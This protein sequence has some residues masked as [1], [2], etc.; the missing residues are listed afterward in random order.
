[1]LRY[2]L[3][4]YQ[5]YLMV[6]LYV[7]IGVYG[8]PAL[9]IFLPLSVFFMKS[10]EL[11]GDMLFGL[12]IVL[13][14]S[15][16]TPWFFSMQIFKGAKNT[17]ISA[18]ALIFFLERYRFVPF[19]K[20]FNV[21]FPFFVYSFFPLI[22]SGTIIVSVQKTISYALL[23]LIIP[24]YVLYNFRRWGWDF[25]KNLIRFMT[26]VLLS[27]FIIL[28]F[29]EFYAY[30][31]GRFRGLFGNPNGL[32]LFCFLLIMLT[33][34]VSE[35]NKDLLNWRDKAF[36][37]GTALYFLIA[38]G[39]RSSLLALIIFLVFGRFFAASPFLG[40]MALIGVFGI[41]EVVLQNLEPIVMFLGIE[42]FV[43]LKT[44]ESGSGR[45]F[46]WE[47]AWIHI[48]DYIVFG[49]GFGTDERIM[50]KHRIYLERMGH[51]GGVHNAYLSFWFDVGI[52][53]LLLFFRSFIL[54]F[55]KASKL[56]PMSIGVMFA[57]LFSVSYESWLVSSLNPFTIILVI[58]LTIVSEEEIV[59][60][61]EELPMP[62][63]QG[64]L[65]LEPVLAI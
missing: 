54:I 25:F 32:A 30:M 22:F 20:V 9:F 5:F 23:Y 57:V 8:G 12:I 15:D 2:I 11:W 24:N 51:Q 60:W 46:A 7:I 55:I 21:F 58:I 18:L 52:I 29:G 59:G 35:I 4:N 45:Y 13:V 65:A 39:S 61:K 28:Y 41:L 47:F 37:Y 62:E 27:G 49:G 36:V 48:Q 50:R 63:D 19:S 34:V 64:D 40:F 16:L 1:M 31:I 53:G 33:T 10:R 17:Y 44:L 38:S 14:L 43:R 26:V 56:V 3:R 6:I 42:D